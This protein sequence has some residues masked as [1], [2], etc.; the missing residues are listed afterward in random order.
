MQ[1]TSLKNSL[2]K[3]TGKSNFEGMTFEMFKVFCFIIS[4]CVASHCVA[5]VVAFDSL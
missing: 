3:K 1:K 4:S 5:F 2:E